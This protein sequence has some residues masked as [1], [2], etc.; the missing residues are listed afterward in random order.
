MNYYCKSQVPCQIDFDEM[1]I[2]GQKYKPVDNWNYTKFDGMY[3]KHLLS[4]ELPAHLDGQKSSETPVENGEFLETTELWYAKLLGDAKYKAQTLRWRNLECYWTS[5]RVFRSIREYESWMV[6]KNDE[7]L[8]NTFDWKCD[9][10]GY[11]ARS[12]QT[13]LNHQSSRN[14]A[15]RQKKQQC[16]EKQ[17]KF[18]FDSETPVF[19]TFCKKTY[20]NKYVYQ[21]HCETA[22]HLL[23]QHK[24]EEL[25]FPLQCCICQKTYKNK[26]GFKRHLKTGQKC[27]SMVGMSDKNRAHWNRYYSKMNCKF[28]VPEKFII[29]EKELCKAVRILQI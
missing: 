11:I 13:L 17:E 29:R 5:K 28:P 10:C 14:C 22:S 24:V 1:V 12:E 7:M 18:L 21:K 4:F 3:Y 23:K 15:I 19:C 8:K 27:H 25:K 6:W 20:A 16:E 9:K 2:S 26:L